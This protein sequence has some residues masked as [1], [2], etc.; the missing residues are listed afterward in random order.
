MSIIS[1]FVAV[2][3]RLFSLYAALA[4]SEDGELRQQVEAWATP[5][6]LAT[7]RG[8][9]DE[10]G[11]STL[12]ID[13]LKEARKLGIVE[14]SESDGRLR[15]AAEVRGVRKKGADPEAEFRAYIS[16]VLFDS[17]RAATAEQSAFMP[18]LAWLLSKNPLQPLNFSDAPQEMLKTDLGDDWE[19]TQ[20]TNRSCYHNLLYWARYLGFAT[21]VGDGQVR[22]VFPDPTAA[23]AER[24]PDIF[25]DN[26]LLEIG[27]FLSALNG[28]F[29]VFEGSAVRAELEVMHPQTF[30]DNEDCLSIATSL[31]LQRLADR[32]AL[33]LEAVADAR[34]RILDL[35]R[36]TIRVSRI[37]RGR[38]E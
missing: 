16:K 7:R 23:I 34:G 19:K 5:P 30:T 20:L 29:P 38:S 12:F 27:S 10:E 33:S 17:S 8:G 2:P 3:S 6:S 28:I 15:V 9:D 25:G 11:S 24:L 14:E 36:E 18:A 1:T 4:D 22:R 35:G 32:G 37:R 31:A 26:P 13:S 21:F